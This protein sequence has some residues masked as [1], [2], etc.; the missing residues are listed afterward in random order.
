[1]AGTAK[2]NR[3]HETKMMNCGI[4]ATIIAY[5]RSDDMDIRF[6]DGYEM[7]GVQYTSFKRGELLSPWSLVGK[8]Q[9]MACG[10]NAKIIASRDKKDIDVM[11]DD[12][13]LV[14]HTSYMNFKSGCIV[15]PNVYIGTYKINKY[16][17]KITIIAYRSYADM[18][19]MFEDGTILEH[20]GYV[21]FKDGSMCHP[22]KRNE[23]HVRKREKNGRLNETKMMNCGMEATIIAYRNVHDIDIRFSDGEIV[24]NKAYSAFKRRSIQNPNI[25]THLGEKRV[26]NCG[27]EAEIVVYRKSIDMDVKFTDGYVSEHR[28]YNEFIRGSIG[29]PQIQSHI[30][31]KVRM[32]FGMEAEII[33]YDGANDVTIRFEDGCEVRRQRIMEFYR[34]E[35]NY[36]KYIGKIR[37]KSFAYRVDLEYYYL[38][39][40]DNTE[41]IMSIGQ[42]RETTGE[43]YAMYY[44]TTNKT[45]KNRVS[46]QK[47]RIGETRRMGC[48]L[49]ATIIAYNG[50]R[51]ISVKF[52][53]GEIVRG[54]MYQAFKQ[55]KIGH[56]KLKNALHAKRI[57]ETRKMECGLKATII[58]YRGCEDLDVKFENNKKVH[59]VTYAK[60]KKG[61]IRYQSISEEYSKLRIGEEQMMNCGMKAKIIAYEN[62]RNIS[63]VFED[64]EKREGVMYGKFTKGNV[65]HPTKSLAQIRDWKEKQNQTRRKKHV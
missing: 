62:V 63:I 22:N 48:G 7:K 47:S 4:T 65:S 58:A 20:K 46:K 30:G 45:K 37:I 40:I 43:R 42:M 64:G 6:A 12:G 55:G 9:V 59:H 27:M 50:N 36:P 14:E 19:V 28:T 51:D 21:H 34:G 8:E 52:E 1:M 49:K 11:F 23:H 38:V 44:R 25:R 13:Y 57:G 56:P 32:K 60:F 18:D 24:R 39:I 54:K 17:D 16:G 15:N 10:M 41:Q 5:R 61:K 53:D 26:M 3:L 35:I 31:K 2:T 29:N 33:A